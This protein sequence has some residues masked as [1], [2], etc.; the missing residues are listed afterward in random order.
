M[1][2]ENVCIVSEQLDKFPQTEPTCVISTQIKEQPRSP[3]CVCFQS[4]PCLP[5]M[6]PQLLVAEIRAAQPRPILSPSGDVWQSLETV[7]IVTVLE[8]GLLL[9]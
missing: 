5:L 9:L 8:V 7:L 2:I 4:L 3:P 6:W 1:Y